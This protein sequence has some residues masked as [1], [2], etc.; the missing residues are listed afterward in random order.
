[1]KETALA[2]AQT[3]APQ[4]IDWLERHLLAC[5]IKEW[6]HLD[7]PGCGFQRSVVALLKGDLA[8][9]WQFYPPGIFLLS[10]L[11]L[12]ILHLIFDLRYGAIVL[13]ILYIVAAIVIGTNY[14]YKVINHQLL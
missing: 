14:I 11:L 1:M 12:L 6:T 7:C 8:A 4:W 2:A 9:S 13:K 5:P 10:T 3:A